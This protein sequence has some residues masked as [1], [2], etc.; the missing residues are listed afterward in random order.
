MGGGERHVI[1]LGGFGHLFFGPLWACS[2]PAAARARDRAASPTSP[3]WQHRRHRHRRQRHRHRPQWR[4]WPFGLHLQWQLPPFELRFHCQRWSSAP[5]TAG[6]LPQRWR[7]GHSQRGP[8]YCGDWPAPA[9]RRISG[10]Y[11]CF[12][13][14][15]QSQNVGY[16]QPPSAVSGR[17]SARCI[18]RSHCAGSAEAFEQGPY[19]GQ[20]FLPAGSCRW[21][22]RRARGHPRLGARILSSLRSPGNA[23]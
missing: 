20:N 16:E 18:H 10:R 19:A 2:A 23:G 9:G 5:G 22:G 13:W 12:A 1:E 3:H 4:S 21:S 8:C 11:P 15:Q 17:W 7:D 14:T 6:W